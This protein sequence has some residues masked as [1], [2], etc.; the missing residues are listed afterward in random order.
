[1]NGTGTPLGIDIGATRVRVAAAERSRSGAVR[2]CA[3]AARDLPEGIAGAKG[4]AEPDVISAI[5]EDLRKELRSTMRRCVIALSASVATIR[6]IRFPTM[7]WLERKRAASFEAERFVASIGDGAQPG[8][9]VTRTHP[10]RSSDRLHA[11]G[12]ARAEAVNVRIRC[13]RRAGFTPAGIDHE[14]CAFRRAFSRCDAAI[15]LGHDRTTL[16]AFG[17]PAPLSIEI[18]VGGSEMTRAIAADLRIDASIAER[19]KRILGMAGAGERARDAYAGRIALAIETMREHAPI[20]RVAL[21]GNGAR[22]PGLAPA[23]ELET[24]ALVET[25]VS[26][27]LQDG[28][29]PEDV[30][31]AAA[32][33]WTLAAA[34][35]AW[36]EP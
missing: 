1:M 9:V 25:P 6:V 14:A 32:T 22:L 15:D 33:D 18:P 8:Q 24:G 10:V 4:L 11:V 23:I 31:G 3:V 13:L 2:L 5:L 17:L 30:V 21:T 16:H 27:L 26:D 7:S 28:A 12:I 35:A 34:L 29:Y 19:R 20:R 36:R